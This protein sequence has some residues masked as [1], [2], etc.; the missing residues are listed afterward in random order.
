MSKKLDDLVKKGT[1]L[2]EEEYIEK[3]IKSLI[4]EENYLV[5]FADMTGLIPDRYKEHNYAIVAGKKLDNRV[6]DDLI[7]G[8]TMEYYNC[9][10]ET[11]RLLS[12]MANKISLRLTELDISNIVVEPTLTDSEITEEVRKT[13]TC[14]FSHKMAGTRAGLGWIGKTDLFISERF[15]PRLRLATVLTDH[16]LNCSN[17]PVNESK[18][19]SCNICVVKCP[20]KA[21]TGELWNIHTEREIFFDPFKCKE[22]CL[23]L[24]QKNIN[25][26]TTMCGIC[27][28]VCPHGKKG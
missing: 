4:D 26:R 8:P 2:Y 15:G 23:E 25:I 28:S 14:D 21:A 9:Y 16:P 19:G 6:I 13:L 3:E 12:E 17:S 10:E 7:D 20:A 24:S 5:G 18:C 11:N 27:V 22:K 1:N